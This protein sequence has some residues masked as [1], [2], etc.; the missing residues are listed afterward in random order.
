MPGFGYC[1]ARVQ[2]DDLHS[3][4]K[5]TSNEKRE[6]RREKREGA[7]DWNGME[8]LLQRAQLSRNHLAVFAYFRAVLQFDGFSLAATTSAVRTVV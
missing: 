2:P 8:W 3:K 4:E 5:R 7:Q 1:G 6:E